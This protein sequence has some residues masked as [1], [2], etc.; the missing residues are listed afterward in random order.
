MNRIAEQIK[1]LVTIRDVLEM[2]NLPVG[3]NG[4]IPCP[5]H[6]GKDPNFSYN[7]K[8]YQCWSC[9]AKGDVITLV[10]EIHGLR[11]GQTL[12]KINNDFRLGLSGK[13]PS[14]RQK[15]RAAE[16][17]QKRKAIEERKQHDREMYLFLCN[18]HARLMRVVGEEKI[19]WLDDFLDENID[20]VVVK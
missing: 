11:F 14:Y 13:K 15:R 1:Q 9:G 12:I 10:M 17:A 3:R 6:N 4:R 7:D 19:T 20:R 2:Y 5:I 18:C 16:V 8:V